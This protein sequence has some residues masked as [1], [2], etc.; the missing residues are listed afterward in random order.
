MNAPQ[1]VLGFFTALAITFSSGAALAHGKGAPGKG[2]PQKGHCVE[3]V[4]GRHNVS[5]REAREICRD[6]K[7]HKAA[8]RRAA[9]DGVIT[10]EEHRALK[11]SKR[12]LRRDAVDAK[13]R[14][15]RRG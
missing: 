8:K 12:E 15:R 10:H 2:A 4:S 6:K 13:D 14:D 5:V 3:R 11:H 9:A 7:H 1:L